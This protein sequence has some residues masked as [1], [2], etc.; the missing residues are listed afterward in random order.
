MQTL[1]ADQDGKV[2]FEV[3]LGGATARFAVTGRDGVAFTP[4]QVT[5]WSQ[6]QIDRLLDAL[7]GPFMAGQPIEE[8]PS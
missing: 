5:T 1:I 2:W 4:G 3:D 8:T 7:L 6:G